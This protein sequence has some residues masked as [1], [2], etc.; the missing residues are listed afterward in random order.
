LYKNLPHSKKNILASEKHVNGFLGDVWSGLAWF[1]LAATA[2]IIAWFTWLWNEHLE[3]LLHDRTHL[4]N[5]PQISA[6][7]V[8]RFYSANFFVCGVSSSLCLISFH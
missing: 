8:S 3:Q 6:L 2:I 4:A 1:F 5:G 7:P